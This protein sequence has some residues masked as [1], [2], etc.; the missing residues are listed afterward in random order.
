MTNATIGETL[1]GWRQS[2][3]LSQDELARE[4]RAPA[5]V[6]RALISAWERGLAL[7]YPGDVAAIGRLGGVS[8]RLV[9]ELCAAVR[10]ARET[11]ARRIGHAHGQ[12]RAMDA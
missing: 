3:R 11:P 7:P 2:A 5:G 6:T 8:P 9:E 10:T 12:R 4:V 1:R